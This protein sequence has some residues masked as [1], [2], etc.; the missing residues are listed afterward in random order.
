VIGPIVRGLVALIGWIR[1]GTEAAVAIE[2]IAEEVTGHSARPPPLP[3]RYSEA[4]VPLT[5]KDVERQRD[6][7]RKAAR[8]FPGPPPRKR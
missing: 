4:P 6:L 8:A 3:D 5:A 2:E 1:T 7:A